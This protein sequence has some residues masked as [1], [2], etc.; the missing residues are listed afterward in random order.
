MTNDE[1]IIALLRYALNK[2]GVS[3][4]SYFIGTK[5]EFGAR[6]DAKCMFRNSDGTWCVMWHERGNF[7][8]LGEFPTI[9][10]AANYLYWSRLWQKMPTLYDY[11]DEWERETGEVM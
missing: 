4:D 5:S 7:K 2:S 10:L 6:L 9:S 3:H 11:L 1:K 8:L